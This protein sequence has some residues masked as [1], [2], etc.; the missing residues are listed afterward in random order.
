LGLSGPCG[1]LFCW[2]LRLFRQSCI[3][4]FSF[5]LNCYNVLDL[6]FSSKAQLIMIILP[7]TIIFCFDSC[8]TFEK[9]N[10]GI[11]QYYGKGK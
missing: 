7:Q 3:L 4:C 9:H 10:V 11:T 6:T 8:W 5:L 1:I 2:I